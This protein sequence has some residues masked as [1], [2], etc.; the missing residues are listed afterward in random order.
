MKT[1]IKKLT[2]ISIS[3]FM[4]LAVFLTATHAKDLVAAQ[5]IRSKARAIDNPQAARTTDDPVQKSVGDL[6][7][8]SDKTMLKN[9][10]KSVG[11]TPTLATKRSEKD[12]VITDDQPLSVRLLEAYF[13]MQL[14]FA[15]SR[16]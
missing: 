10:A 16:S 8:H 14:A 1:K 7:N 15:Y 5:P 2:T 9:F 3:L 12:D 4:V 13:M 6:H 11:D